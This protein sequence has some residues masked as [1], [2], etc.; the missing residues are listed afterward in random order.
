MTVF[1]VGCANSRASVGNVSGSQFEGAR[2]QKVTGTLAD[3]LSVG[4][5]GGK[6][7]SDLSSL[8]RKKALE[9]EYKALETGRSG[10]PVNWEGSEGTSGK[11]VPQQPY[12]VGN[13]DCRRYA[14]TITQ[15]GSTATGT[16]TAC[17]DERGAWIP[18]S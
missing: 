4:I 9:A 6:L 18:L 12:Q 16:G 3:E 10:N 17:R 2:K 1:L 13:S 15:D 5:L 11:I 7:G 8:S 14:H